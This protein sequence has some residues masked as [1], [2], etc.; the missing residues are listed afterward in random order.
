MEK[1][2]EMAE[3]FSCGDSYDD[4]DAFLRVCICETGRRSGYGECTGT[5]VYIW[6]TDI[7]EYAAVTKQWA[8]VI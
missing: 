4:S 7:F 1:E 2:I 6:E 3:Y 8:A 5:C